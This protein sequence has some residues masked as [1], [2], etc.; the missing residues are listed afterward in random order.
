MPQAL[1]PQAFHA[2]LAQL[3]EEQVADAHERELDQTAMTEVVKAGL[4]QADAAAHGF[5]QAR[6]DLEVSARAGRA[7]TRTALERMNGN[8]GP[9]ATVRRGG[10]TIAGRE[11]E[12]DDDTEV[13]DDEV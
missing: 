7:H 13:E 2:L 11:P 6:R 8:Y 9:F 4:T 3:A 12:T 10:F 1:T 5:F